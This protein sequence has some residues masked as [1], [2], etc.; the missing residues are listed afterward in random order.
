M[1]VQLNMSP[2][3]MQLE[4]EYAFSHKHID[5]YIQTAIRENPDMEAKVH[6][7]V[8]RLNDWRSQSYYDSKDLRLAQLEN[9]DMEV[10]VRTIFT[11]IAYC[12]KPELF[13]SVTSQLSSRLEFDD[14]ED[15][16]KT[17]AEIVAV[18][19]YTDA[20]DITKADKHASMM[21]ES[22]MALPTDLLDAIDRSQY[23]PPMVCMP[24]VVQTNYESPY[25]THNDC[26][27]LG[28]KNGHDGD[29]CLD[30]INLQ[31]SVGLQL[32]EEFLQAVDEDPT[33]ALDTAEKLQVWTQFKDQSAEIYELMLNQ[34]NHFWLTNK[35][36][37]R[38]RL[39]AQGYHITSQGSS[40]KKAMLELKHE[41]I[42]E[43]V[44]A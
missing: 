25:L 23:L 2:E 41:E 42:I 22:C 10:L 11:G 4:N 12:T 40:Y 27:I 7:G 20:F 37:K 24:D 15:S 39:Y 16:I 34:G 6:E 33:Y 32:S 5:G 19:C 21:I 29:I 38:G 18:L 36:D 9:L 31:N 44:P 8:Q 14:R 30:V 26:L 28:K 3:D 13:V 17:V 43:D 35:P 1:S